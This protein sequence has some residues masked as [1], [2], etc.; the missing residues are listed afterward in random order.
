ME[1]ERRDIAGTSIRSRTGGVPEMDPE[2][3][4][5]VP[6]RAAVVKV[7]QVTADDRRQMIA[8]AAYLRAEKRGFAPGGEVEDWLA[9]ET[10]VDALLAAGEGPA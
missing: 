7:R 2:L 9:A 10:E 6:L 8:E 1:Q 4:A 3:R 5:R